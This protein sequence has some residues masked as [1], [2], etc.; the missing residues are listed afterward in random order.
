MRRL[1]V[2]LFLALAC[3]R[4]TEARLE[5]AQLEPPVVVRTDGEGWYLGRRIAPTMSYH[6]ADWLVRP[7][8]QAEEDAAR[9]LEELRLAPGMVACDVG[10]GNGY[11]TL[12]MAKAV[13]PG[14]RAIAVDI[15][16][17]MLTLLEERAKAA[18][19][20]NVSTVLGAD[21]DPKLSQATCD[22]VLMADVYH[23]LADPEA[24]LRRLREALTPRGQLVLLEFRAEDPDVP[25]KEEHKMSKAQVL[26]ELE[27]NGFRLARSFDGLPWQHL[28]FFV[29]AE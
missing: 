18:G 7:E 3:G 4:K 27:H 25:I 14:G 22:L 11:H 13:R 21:A 1:G 12:E 26:R 6:G 19:V 24:V 20:A 28:L 5:P 23:E 10:A 17:E 8:R 15:Q 2:A 16:P 29:P 9:M